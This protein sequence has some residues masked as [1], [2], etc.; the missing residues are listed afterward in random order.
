VAI[1]S[2]LNYKAKAP[3]KK[4][5][6]FCFMLTDQL[7]LHLLLSQQR[8]FVQLFVHLFIRFSVVVLLKQK[9]FIMA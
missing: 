7:F 6:G 3:A 1:L 5:G 8:G 9:L 4:C 2:R